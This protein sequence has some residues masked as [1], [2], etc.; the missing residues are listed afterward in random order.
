MT[1]GYLRFLVAVIACLL[2]ALAVGLTLQPKEPHLL[3][4]RSYRAQSISYLSGGS[5]CE[6]AEVRSVR[7]NLRQRKMNACRERQEEHGNTANSL[8]EAR[9]AA[10]AAQA[11]A[12]SSYQ[13]TRIAALGLGAGIATLLAAIGAAVFAER[14]AH[15]TGRNADIATM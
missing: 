2:A 9:R 8:L 14:A 15:H 4:D 6:A 11:G 3:G 12:I 13:Q 10:D 1:K 7:P 5:G